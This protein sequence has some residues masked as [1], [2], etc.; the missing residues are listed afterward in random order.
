MIAPNEDGKKIDILFVWDAEFIPFQPSN[1]WYGIPVCPYDL[2]GLCLIDYQIF[3]FPSEYIFELI[4]YSFFIFYIVFS[5]K[6][7]IFLFGLNLLFIPINQTVHH[8]HQH[9]IHLSLFPPYNIC[10][11][12]ICDFVVWLQLTTPTLSLTLSLF[13]FEWVSEF[14]W[15]ESNFC[16]WHWF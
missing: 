7:K 6:K 13:L 11:L 15:E 10:P 2:I 9:T 12:C 5:Y 8:L 14:L 1:E 3:K 4:F 16:K